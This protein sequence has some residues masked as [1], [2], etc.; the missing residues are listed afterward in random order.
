MRLHHAY[1]TV[2]VAGLAQLR[3]FYAGLLGLPEIPKAAALG[4]APLIWFKVGEDHLHFR[5]DDSWERGRPDHHLAFVFDDL[6]PVLQRL[7]AD[8]Y[9]VQQEPSFE[10]YGYQRYYVTDPFGRRLE[11]MTGL[12]GS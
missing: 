10:D 7:K 9:D 11:L 1:Q 12:Q 6:T 5:L 2:P 4:D 3:H 8:G